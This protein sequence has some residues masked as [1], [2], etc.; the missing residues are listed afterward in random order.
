MSPP[1]PAVI[2]P[3]TTAV[4]A[5]AK[6]HPVDPSIIVPQAVAHRGYS[7]VY[8]ENSMAGFRGAIEEAGAQALETDVH[9]SRDGVVVLAHDNSL[10][11]CFGRPQRVHELDFAELA[12]LRS[13]RPPHV[14]MPSLQELLEYLAEPQ[15]SAI[16]MILDIKLH[17]DAVQLF[18]G[19]ADVLARVPSPHRPWSQRILVGCWKPGYMALSQTYLPGIPLAH[20][21]LSQAYAASAVLPE[22]PE[23]AL[24]LAMAT[25]HGMNARSL[26][27]FAQSPLFLWTVNDEAYMAWAVEHVA[28]VGQRVG[29]VDAVVTD[30][31]RRFNE[32]V[33]RA[34]GPPG[35]QKRIG[36]LDWIK[37]ALIKMSMRVVSRVLLAGGWY[38]QVTVKA[39]VPKTKEKAKIEV[40]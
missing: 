7:A 30:D 22:Y 40:E 16:W 39:A 13:L 29:G 10:K 35:W 5:R 21:G 8:P 9:L 18:Q 11:R 24:N 32:V 17:D 14:P 26:D 37:M 23:C 38:G 2:N 34:A 19:I 12:K 6:P 20:I 15:N 3:N 33:A 27:E 28:L 4:W 1:N 31:P 36:I 25:V